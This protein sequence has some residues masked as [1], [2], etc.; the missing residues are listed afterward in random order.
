MLIKRSFGVAG[1]RESRACSTVGPSL[2]AAAV[3]CCKAW[4]LAVLATIASSSVFGA[5]DDAEYAIRWNPQQGGPPSASDALKLLRLSP[6]ESDAF[7][8]E[9]FDVLLPGDTPTGFAAIARQRTT[10]QKSE[11]TLKYRG[12]NRL[13]LTSTLEQWQCSLNGSAEKK[14][15]VDISF[16]QASETK[17]MY[18][19][20]CSVKGDAATAIPNALDAKPKGCKSSMT[21][22]KSKDMKAEEW[23]LS[24]GAKVIEVSLS[25]KDTKM[26]L[27]NFRRSVVDVLINR[28][29]T[30]LDR[31]K[32]EMGS[33]CE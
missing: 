19:R 26:E 1:P 28:G 6:T 30:P 31:S 23:Q 18:S 9:Y 16:G 17:R 33:E 8:V 25:G 20:S 14:E 10:K 22:L 7:V 5:N 21:R 11:V 32:S 13:P 29:V 15:E 12:P 2:V 27:E 3:H 4:L 24:S